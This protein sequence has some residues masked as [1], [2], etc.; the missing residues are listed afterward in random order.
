[1]TFIVLVLAGALLLGRLRGGS[2]DRLAQLPMRGA[3]LVVVAALLGAIGAQAGRLGLPA[4]QAVYVGGTVASAALV[5]VFVAQN[6]RLVGVP[7]IAV[8]FAL[9]AAVIIANG[10]MPVSRDTAAYAG[11]DIDP[12]LAGD[13]AKH[14]LMTDRT[15]LRLLADIV[16]VP[17]PGP[18]RFGSNVISAG[19]VVLAAGIAQLVTAGMHG[20]A[21]G[22]RTPRSVLRSRRSS[23]APW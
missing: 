11:I 12:L 15:R 9:N 6:R 13:D 1:M 7:L 5:A 4:P 18:L 17:L 3:A 2:F 8:G 23:P 20:S 14:E 19:D 10:A 22:R 21:G 16:P